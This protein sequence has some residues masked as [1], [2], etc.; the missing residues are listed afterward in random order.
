MYGFNS[1]SHK[2]QR[3]QLQLQQLREALYVLKVQAQQRLADY[4]LTD[5]I[6]DLKRND[7]SQLLAD[8]EQHVQ[9]FLDGSSLT[10][11]NLDIAGLA[12]RFIQINPADVRDRI[13]DLHRLR[14]RL[15]KHLALTE[16]DFRRLDDVQ[17][18]LEAEAAEGVRS[19]YGF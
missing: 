8:L 7:I 9:L 14:Q 18:L 12:D 1:T 19:L 6:A 2:H 15:D 10:T 16:R 5:E 3:D 11:T 4:H 17:S 13:D